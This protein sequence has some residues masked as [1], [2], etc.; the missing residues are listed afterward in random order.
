M[1]KSL[2]REPLALGL[3]RD[4]TIVRRRTSENDE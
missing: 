4:D 3:N 1:L 2:L